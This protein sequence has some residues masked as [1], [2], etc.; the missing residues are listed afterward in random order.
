MLVVR[1]VDRD[2]IMRYHWGLAVGHTYSHGANTTT[3]TTVQ[4]GVDA[5]GNAGEM[6]NE[7]DVICRS[8]GHV[9][10]DNP[11]LSLDNW[12]DAE[13]ET[14]G[15]V[16][17]VSYPQEHEDYSYVDEPELDCED[18]REAEESSEDEDR[19]YDD[20]DLLLALDDMYGLGSDLDSHYN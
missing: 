18:Q 4:S 13:P 10:V 11:E 20:D 6:M 1:F 3:S 14:T 15:E 19:E 17:L 2:M 9:D 7:T 16:D 12:Q 8:L 5:T